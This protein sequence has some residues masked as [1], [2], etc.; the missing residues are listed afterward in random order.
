MHARTQAEIYVW[1]EERQVHVAA[2]ERRRLEA[3]QW[4]RYT[5][6]EPRPNP[7]SEADLN[8]YC[9]V[10]AEDMSAPACDAAVRGCVSGCACLC[11]S[12][13]GGWD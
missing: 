6:C 5:E 1:L 10:W 8:T 2:M 11:V 13:S 12:F 7:L 3:V 4:D 9:N